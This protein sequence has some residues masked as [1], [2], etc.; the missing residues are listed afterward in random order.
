MCK[1]TRFVCYVLV[2]ASEFKRLVDGTDCIV[3]DST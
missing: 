3:Q 2:R 1:E